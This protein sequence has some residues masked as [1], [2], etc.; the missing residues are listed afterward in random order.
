MSKENIQGLF[1]IEK[2]YRSAGTNLEAGTGLGL[3][4]C[5]EFLDKNDGE[6]RVESQLNIGSSFIFTL[7][8]AI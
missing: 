3:V 1:K 4:L 7:N 8:S 5:K 2:N 6:I